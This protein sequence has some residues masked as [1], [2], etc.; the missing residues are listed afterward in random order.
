MRGSLLCLYGT[1]ALAACLPIS[2]SYV[3]T[4]RVRG[5]FHTPDG[6]P[7]GLQSV[8]VAT[9]SSCAAPQSVT[10]TDSGGAFALPPTRQHLDF[11]LLVPFDR[12]LPRYSVCGRVAS[13]W[14]PIARGDAWDGDQVDSI[15]CVRASAPGRPP[16]CKV[17]SNR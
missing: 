6:T 4:P 7:L 16:V 13:R 15:I 2:H 10:L 8:A 17:R 14:V 11:I 1:I 3:I 12:A 9:D 5:T